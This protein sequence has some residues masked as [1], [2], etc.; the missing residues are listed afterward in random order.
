MYQQAQGRVVVLAAAVML[1]GTA[2]CDAEEARDPLAVTTSG[3]PRVEF[4]RSSSYAGEEALAHTMDHLK[5]VIEDPL[6][7]GGRTIGTTTGPGTAE[8]VLV[9][10]ESVQ[11]GLSRQAVSDGPGMEDSIQNWVDW[12]LLGASNVYANGLPQIMRTVFFTAWTQ[13]ADDGQPIWVGGRMT[14]SLTPAWGGTGWSGTHS[15]YG[16]W[17]GYASGE[18]EVWING[19]MQFGYLS[20]HHW[21]LTSTGYR[22]GTSTDSQG[23]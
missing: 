11:A 16:G 17:Q 19:D 9:E 13:T 20:T 18:Y 8:E 14:M 10:L 15:F 2:A 3:P 7:R 5:A 22:S 23:V 21:A 4:I 12:G 1:V 6:I